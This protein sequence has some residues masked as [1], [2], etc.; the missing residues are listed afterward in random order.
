MCP[1]SDSEGGYFSQPPGD[2]SGAG[3]VTVAKTVG[4]TGTESNDIFQ[5]AAQFNT[6]HVRIGKDTEIR[7]GQY[8]LYFP[9]DSHI[10]GSHYRGR[11]LAVEYL[12][13]Q[14]GPGEDADIGP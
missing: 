5:S 2:K 14:I 4:D 10:L 9:G 6:D 12:T 13:G 8:P 3:I 11:R 7:R 1:Q